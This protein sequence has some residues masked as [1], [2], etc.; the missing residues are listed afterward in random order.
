LT[1]CIPF[2]EPPCFFEGPALGEFFFCAALE[3]SMVN[4]GELL[5][6][7]LTVRL[8]IAQYSK[9]EHNSFIAQYP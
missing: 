7:I 3:K 6:S 5:P 1:T 4:L 2:G 9:Q 8:F